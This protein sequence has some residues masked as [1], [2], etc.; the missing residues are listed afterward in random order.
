MTSIFV[1][2]K[3]LRSLGKRRAVLGELVANRPVVFDRV[4]AVKRHR[5]DQMNQDRCP[6]HVPQEFV[7]EAMARVRPLDQTGNIRHDEMMLGRHHGPQI[8][9]FRRERIIGDLGM[10]ARDT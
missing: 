8:G 2:T 4:G 10:G 1:T 3:Q 5:L 6:F 9:I 7:T